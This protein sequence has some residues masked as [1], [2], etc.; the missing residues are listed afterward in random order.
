[1]TYTKT[2]GHYSSQQSVSLMPDKECMIFSKSIFFQFSCRAHGVGGAI[3]ESIDSCQW[4]DRLRNR[5]S[6][7]GGKKLA[8]LQFHLVFVLMRYWV[9]WERQRQRDKTTWYASS[10][11][12]DFVLFFWRKTASVCF[13]PPKHPQ[14]SFQWVPVIHLFTFGWL[15]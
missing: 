3:Y 2:A 14:L 6:K 1:M 12:F 7:T 15:A 5:L 8:C 13:G 10:Y 9:K 4:G 11:N